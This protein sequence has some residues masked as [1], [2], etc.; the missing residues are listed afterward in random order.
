MADGPLWVAG[1]AVAT[2]T[3]DGTRRLVADAVS[4]A[5]QPAIGI[6]TA[7]VIVFKAEV[8]DNSASAWGLTDVDARWPIGGA[9]AA[10]AIAA[11]RAH[12]SVYAGAIGSG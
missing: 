2:A 8:P 7:A 12:N 10:A 4:S 1:L 5:G 11:P 3:N 6:T 9:E